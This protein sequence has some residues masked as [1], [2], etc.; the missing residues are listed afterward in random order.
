[1]VYHGKPSMACSLCRIRKIKVRSFEVTV[2]PTNIMQCD[3]IRPACSQCVRV[4]A[5]C[6]GYRSPSDLIFRDQRPAVEQRAYLRAAAQLL[7]KNDDKK[8]QKL[9]KLVRAGSIIATVCHTPHLVRSLPTP[10]SELVP[11]LFF[12]YFDV[13]DTASGHALASCLPQTISTADDDALSVAVSSVGYALLSNITKSSDK[14]IM[15]RQKYGIAVRL[16]C[17]VIQTCVASE[18]CWAVRVI[19]ILAFFEVSCRDLPF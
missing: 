6:H 2:S 19:L 12:Q 10:E 7:E 14:L 16:T 1:M 9:A 18:T 5:E 17:N 3:Q 4:S 15:A 13:E 11:S 8:G